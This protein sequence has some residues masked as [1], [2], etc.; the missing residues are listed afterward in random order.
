MIEKPRSGY[1]SR[2]NYHTQIEAGSKA[3]PVDIVHSLQCPERFCV[4]IAGGISTQSLVGRQQL[5]FV[6]AD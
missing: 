2:L 3:E 1:L 5:L 6:T 4:T